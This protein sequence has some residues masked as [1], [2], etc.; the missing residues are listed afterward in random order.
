MMPTPEQNHGCGTTERY[1]TDHFFITDTAERCLQQRDRGTCA[2]Q[3][4]RWHWDAERRT[5]QVFTYSGCGGN[6]NNFASR[7]E[8]FAVC[9]RPGN[10]HF[11]FHC[12]LKC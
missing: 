10:V 4:I 3:F 1:A 7:E 2:G 5:C 11:S 9:H 8:C 6:G 12:L